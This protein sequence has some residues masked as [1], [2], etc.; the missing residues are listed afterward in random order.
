MEVDEQRTLDAV[1]DQRAEIRRPEAHEHDRDREQCQSD[2]QPPR[3]RSSRNRR[4]RRRHGNRAYCAAAASTS[5]DEPANTCRPSG[6]FTER[7][8]ATCC[9]SFDKKPLIVT[10]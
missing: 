7:A 8:F 3:R 6:S 1:A 4:C 9:W 10:T 5:N 2:I